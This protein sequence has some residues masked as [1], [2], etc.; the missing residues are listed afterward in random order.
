LL[1]FLFGLSFHSPGVFLGLVV[2]LEFAADEVEE[3]GLPPEEEGVAEDVLGGVFATLVEAVH[4][5]LA[6]EGVD[7]PVAEVLGEDVLLELLDLLD[8]ELTPIGHPMDDRLVLS[9][10]QDFEALLDEIRHRRV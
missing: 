4:V 6:D 8:R 3:G 5:E 9:V 10:L 1:D 7:V 2:V